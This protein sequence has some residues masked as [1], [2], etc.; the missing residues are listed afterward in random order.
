[1]ALALIDTSEQIEVT[2]AELG[3]PD[4]DPETVYIL[5]PLDVT[6]YRALIKDHTSY[7]INKR[8]HQREEKV[9]GVALA[10]AVFDYILAGWRGVQLKGQ[11]V[12][13]EWAYKV[14]LDPARRSAL[15]DQAGMNRVERSPEDRAESFRRA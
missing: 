3:V 13:C 1:M 9:D 10:D 4:G 11:P 15:L 8:T 14:L 12:P 7:V 6:K 5:N 2:D